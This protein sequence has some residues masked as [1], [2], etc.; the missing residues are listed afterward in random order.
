VRLQ[1]EPI[2]DDR[3]EQ[4]ESPRLDPRTGELLWV[5]IKNGTVHRG[6]LEG[7][8]IRTVA[9]YDIGVPVGSIA[10]LAEPGAGWV[11]AVQEGFAHLSEPGLVKPIAGGLTTGSDQMNDGVCDPQG[12][13]WAGSQAIP[14]RTAAALFRLDTDGS[15]RRMLD[16]VTVSNGIGFTAD[17]TTMYYIDTLPH[18]RLEAF[19]VV[20]GGLTGRRV[21][22]DVAGGNPDG[23]AVDDEGCVW[24]AVWDGAA[25][26]RY[27][28]TGHLLAVV[29]LPVPRP[30]AVCFAGT[31]LLITTA[32][33]GLEAASPDS[34]RIF[35]AEVGVGGPPAHGWAGHVPSDGPTGSARVSGDH[36]RAPLTR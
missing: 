2:S 35:A 25:V 11:L 24:V 27:S 18:R 31:T 1:A 36:G 28:P 26:H 4:G 15:V 13:F 10:P 22:A 7:G 6:R 9:S 5:D 32:W 23:L 34:G 16:G 14:R 21:V 8:R 20:D 30:S 17:A 33:L 12:R 19:D 29:D 3:Y